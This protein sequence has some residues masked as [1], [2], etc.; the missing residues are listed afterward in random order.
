MCFAPPGPYRYNLSRWVSSPN[1]CNKRSVRES[2]SEAVVVLGS[3]GMDL[4][5]FHLSYFRFS[6]P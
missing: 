5:N 3:A 1:D 2:V 4:K 6:S